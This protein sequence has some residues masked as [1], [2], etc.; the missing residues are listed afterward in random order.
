MRQEESIK[1]IQEEILRGGLARAIFLKGSLARGQG[2]EYADVDF[3]CIVEEDKKEEFLSKRIDYMES[4]RP[5]L[6]WSESNFVGPQIVGVFDNGLHFDLY[7][8]TIDKLQ[9]T[10]QIKVLH[11][12]EGLLTGY[13]QQDLSISQDDVVELY[14]EFSFSLL[15]FETA[16]KRKDLLWASRLGGHLSGYLSVLLRYVYDKENARLGMKR[17]NSKLDKDTYKEFLNA[18]DLLGPSQVNYGV[19]VLCD[20]AVGTMEKLPSEIADRINKK[21]LYFMID[22][23]KEL[24]NERR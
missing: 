2:D 17:L 8:I 9:Y 7:T 15:E 20:I 21:F 4:Y 12:P 5:L 22:K 10:D 23:I 24:R 16:Y 1:A 13:K 19:E 6:Y 3:Y 14:G 11:D 18:L